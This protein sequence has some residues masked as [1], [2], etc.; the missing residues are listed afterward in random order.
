MAHEPLPTILS[1]V[2]VKQQQL[3]ALPKEEKLAMTINMKR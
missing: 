2:E 3:D 1:C